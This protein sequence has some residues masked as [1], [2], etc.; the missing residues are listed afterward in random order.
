MS[1]PVVPSEPVL[2]P[3]CKILVGPRHE[4]CPACDRLMEWAKSRK[5]ASRSPVFW[6]LPPLALLLL[7]VLANLPSATLSPRPG[8]GSVAVVRHAGAE[9]AW[10]A[11]DDDAFNTLMDSQTNRSGELLGYLVEKGRAFRE[12]NGSRVLVVKKAPG[13]FFVKVRSGANE[14]YEGWVQAELLAPTQP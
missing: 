11:T 4:R 1:I 12:P 13:S 9:G 2:C 14:G 7:I 5:R 3:N 6:L 10:L 8:V